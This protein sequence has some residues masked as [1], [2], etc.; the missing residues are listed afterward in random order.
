MTDRIQQHISLPGAPAHVY[1]A[2]TDGA[3]FGDVTGAPATID[4]TTGGAFSC[5]GGMIEGRNV[6]C[7]EGKRLVQAWR[8]KTWDDGVFSIVRFEL[9]AEGDGT[10]LTLEHAGFPEGQAEHLA[11]GWHSNYWEPLKQK[12]A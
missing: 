5:F 7:V 1:A 9:D 12:L 10:K 11:A 6:E 4:P 2:L 3:R 8:A